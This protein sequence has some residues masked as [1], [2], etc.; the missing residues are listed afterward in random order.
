MG[1]LE[2]SIENIGL[3][4]IV[5]ADCTSNNGE[6]LIVT[7]DSTLGL[8]Y[9]LIRFDNGNVFRGENKDGSLFGTTTVYEK[10]DDERI[11]ITGPV[12]NLI[13]DGIGEI[14]YKDGSIIKVISILV[15]QMAKV[16]AHS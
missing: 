6:H 16:N 9:N 15:S 1:D 14:T 2:D 8:N 12:K 3:G 7:N 13:F 5:S 10:S 4:L 11:L